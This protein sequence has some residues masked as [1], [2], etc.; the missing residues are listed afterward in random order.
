MTDDVVPIGVQV[1]AHRKCNEYAYI[2]VRLV[3]CEK[4]VGHQG[5][6]WTSLFGGVDYER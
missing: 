1:P 2:H 4:V 5:D 3:S 6:H